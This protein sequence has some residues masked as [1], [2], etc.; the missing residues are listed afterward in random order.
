MATCEPKDQSRG[1]VA[2]SKAKPPRDDPDRAFRKAWK[3]LGRLERRLVAA[4]SE[5]AKRLHQLGDGSGTK[6]AQ[7][8]AQ[9][10]AAQTRIAEIEGLLTELSELIASNAR[11]RS[12]RVV[13]EVANEAAIAVR[14]AAIADAAARATDIAPTAGASPAH[15]SPSPARAWSARRA[16]PSDN[17]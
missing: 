17:G 16:K 13:A 9:L 14:E 8:S 4:R 5:E 2:K 1:D 10:E 15:K 12:G 7:R 3:L 6:A 11:A